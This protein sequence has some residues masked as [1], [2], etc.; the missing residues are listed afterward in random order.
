[1]ASTLAMT[2]VYNEKCRRRKRMIELEKWQGL[3]GALI[4]AVMGF[5]GAVYV[6]SQIKAQSRRSAAM[7]LM[8]EL[9][10]VEAVKDVVETGSLRDRTQAER[11]ELIPAAVHRWR[12]RLTEQFDI[13]RAEIM[14]LGS[15]I[16]M[17]LGIVRKSEMQLDFLL[18]QY[19]EAKKNGDP[20]FD[21]VENSRA[22]WAWLRIGQ[23]AAAEAMWLLGPAT[24]D[25]WK[26]WLMKRQRRIRPTQRDKE[27][28]GNI[29][30]LAK[31]V[32]IV[33]AQSGPK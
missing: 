19:H 18:N 1:M 9:A 20:A 14:D 3:V 17:R 13:Q 6:A 30:H 32:S 7:Y 27:L 26:A 28:W 22:I 16:G 25:V 23:N 10:M 2:P 33:T 31:A 4:G 15:L 21:K 12:Y 24:K 11:D 5:V 29:V 8:V